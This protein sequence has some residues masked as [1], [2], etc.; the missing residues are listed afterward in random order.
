MPLLRGRTLI[1]ESDGSPSV[2]FGTLNLPNGTLTDN[3]DNTGT[4]TPA[5]GGGQ[6][7]YDAIVAGS[8]GDYT[9]LGAAV[10]AGKKYIFVRDGT[11][12][13]SSF[14]ASA[15]GLQIVG[16]S[17]ENTILS[18]AASNAITLSG[19][20][21]TITN[22]K[23]TF[24]A[25]GSTGLY[26]DGDYSQA[27]NLHITNSSGSSAL[28]YRVR[29][30][31]S[32]TYGCLFEVKTGI[33]TVAFKWDNGFSAQD[34]L[35]GNNIFKV[36]SGG[37]SSNS[38]IDIQHPNFLFT[39][40]LIQVIS[41]STGAQNQVNAEV[42]G[43][44]TG[45]TFNSF[46]ATGQTAI[47]AG[48][49]EVT[50]S[51]CNFQ[52]FATV[53]NATAD[54]CTVTGNTSIATSVTTPNGV[55]VA[56]HECVVSGNTFFG[57]TSSLA[58][59]GVSIGAFDDAAVT[60]NRIKGF[61]TGVN[62]TSSSADRTTIS[63]N[64]LAGNTTNLTDTGNST[65]IEGNSGLDVNSNKHF[66]YMKNTSGGTIN[67]GDTV[68]LKSV[69][70]GDEITTTTTASDELVFGMSV[71]SIANNAYGYIQ[72]LGK[73]T[74]MKADGTT[75]IAI[76]DFLTT[77]TSA[78]IV[79]KAATGTLGTTPGDLAIAIALEAYTANDS[80]GVLDALIIPPRRL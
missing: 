28:L 67:V 43:T 55:N 65:T 2:R 72:T 14:T 16:E 44:I 79:G 31:Y 26:I 38:P 9:T 61:A 8:G 33:N 46:Q 49:A 23:I 56:G 37:S 60:G 54:Y 11:Y 77:F 32:I 25:N 7:L 42:K 51:G 13:E 63:G 18:L 74:L 35:I 22:L 39:G 71:E 75:D 3:G 64:S 78:G 69:A 29:G 80:S 1:Q 27:T 12:S 57:R 24:A 58:G 30:N 15:V 73:T 5:A 76:G 20:N 41:Q 40:N 21:Q 4:Y 59:T 66:V 45:C 68:V 62:I 47:K 48:G 19:N 36:T 34:A 53:V 17:R 52:D 70:A 10:A 50:I 6:T